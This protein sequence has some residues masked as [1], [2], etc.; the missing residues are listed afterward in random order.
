MCCVNNVVST[1]ASISFTG[2]SGTFTIDPVLP[3]QYAWAAASGGQVNNI[4]CYY[5]LRLSGGGTTLRAAAVG[6]AA[7]FIFPTI[8][9]VEI[10]GGHGID[11][12]DLPSSSASGS[13]CITNS[14]TTTHAAELAIGFATPGA[15]RQYY[16]RRWI[17]PAGT[18]YLH[19]RSL[20]TDGIGGAI[21][22][23]QRCG[24]L[25]VWIKY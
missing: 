9:A 25:D 1:N 11:Q 17:Y 21:V 13:T 10:N 4:S 8:V 18:S 19:Q 7:A 2:D 20:W 16:R 14:V 5:V 12:S 6:G 3:F 22:H 23:W 24:N 15:P